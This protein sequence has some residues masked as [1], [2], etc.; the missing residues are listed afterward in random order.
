MED[1]TPVLK[2]TI[3]SFTKYAFI[4]FETK[5][6]HKI[7]NQP[8]CREWCKDINKLIKTNK[9]LN[10]KIKSINKKYEFSCEHINFKLI[11]INSYMSFYPSFNN[12]EGNI[13]A[14]TFKINKELLDVFKQMNHYYN[15]KSLNNEII[16]KKY[17]VKLE[18]NSNNDKLT[19]IFSK[20][21]NEINNNIIKKIELNKKS[22]WNFKYNGKD[23]A[24]CVDVLNNKYNS[25]NINK[26]IE[27]F[28]K[29][30]NDIYLCLYIP[31]SIRKYDKTLI[32]FQNNIITFVDEQL[33]KYKFK[34][35]YKI[36]T[37][38]IDILKA[39]KYLIC[40]IN[41]IGLDVNYQ[42]DY[43]YFD[44]NIKSKYDFLYGYIYD[45]KY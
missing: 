26:N 13:I 42:N 24:C 30:S 27:N 21:N 36:K 9:F 28:F 43:P 39:M 10:N 22:F 5:S 25:N 33:N 7:V 17:N 8:I 6:C 37:L 45:N 1:Y 20:N 35:N 15:K 19:L 29:T 31:I 18:T 44:E 40:D 4:V 32:Y 12:N 16:H 11:I 2:T 14:L 38:L 3:E 34:Y 23:M 41:D